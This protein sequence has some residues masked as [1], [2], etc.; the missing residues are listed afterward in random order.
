MDD[1]TSIWDS[2]VII[3]YL[4]DKYGSDD[5]LYPKDLVIRAKV[6][7]RLFFE[8]SNLSPKLREATFPIFFQDGLM[9]PQDKVDDMYASLNILETFL[10]TNSYLVG[11]DWTIAD[12]SVANTILLLQFYAPLTNE[13]FPKILEWLDRI[14]QN[15]PYFAEINGDYPTIMAEAIAATVERNKL[16]QNIWSR[17]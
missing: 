2:H 3:A 6:N 16:K 10:N 7:Q 4:V 5:Q 9:P 15:V 11:N 17:I 13:K 1:G 12:V 8:A 14:D